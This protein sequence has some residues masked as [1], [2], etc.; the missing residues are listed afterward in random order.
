MGTTRALAGEVIDI[1]PFGSALPGTATAI[2]VKTETLEVIRLVVLAGRQVAEHRAKGVITVQ[3]LEG[4]VQFTVGD[5]PRRLDA[6]GLLYLPKG[7]R[8][9]LLGI[10]DASL[11]VTIMLG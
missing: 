1:S 2:L 8:H 4:S 3:C 6:G 11:L 10:H 9:A 7:E 5:E